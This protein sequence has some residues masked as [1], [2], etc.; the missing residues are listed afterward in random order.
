MIGTS[1]PKS[2]GAF[3]LGAPFSNTLKTELCILKITIFKRRMRQVSSA[4]GG[5]KKYVNMGLYEMDSVVANTG[6]VT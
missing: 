4:F 5:Y 1:G 3:I 6:S 2:K